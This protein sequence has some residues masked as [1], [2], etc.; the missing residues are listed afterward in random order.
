MP[1]FISTS[2]CHSAPQTEA[3]NAEIMKE[4]KE[5]IALVNKNNLSAVETALKNGANVNSTDN[6]KRS[7][8]LIATNN[9]HAEMAKLLVKYKADVNQ[10]ASNQDS[11]FLYAGASGQTL[12]TILSI[13]LTVWD[14]PL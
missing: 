14:G 6:N 8:L 7:L 9:G 4:D 3:F 13:I 10:Q 11:P 5:L 2:A 12:K 1:L